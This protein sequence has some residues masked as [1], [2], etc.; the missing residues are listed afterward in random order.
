MDAI[1]FDR[2]IRAQ[3]H[4]PA[5]NAA[6]LGLAILS[7][8]Y[9]F[10]TRMRAFAYDRRWLPVHQ[11]AIPVVSIGNLTLGG[12]G[13]TPMV[14]WVSRW[15][16]RH[17]IRVVI[18]SRGYGATHGPNDE[19][20]V[21]E[22]N[23]PDCPHLQGADRVQLARIAVEELEGQV[24]ILDDA[25]QHRRL[26]RDLDIVL[27]DALEPFGLN[28]LFPRG[29]L[30]EPVSALRRAHVVVL[31][32]A[33]QVTPA[34][35]FAIRK[36][37]ESVC[38]RSL[39]WV[40]VRHAPRAASVHQEHPI[41][42]TELPSFRSVGFCGIGNPQAFRQTLADLGVQPVDF[43]IFPDHHPYSRDDVARLADWIR[44]TH[45]ELAL[46]TQ[47]DS[48]KLLLAHLGPARIAAIEIGL[49]ILQGAEIL[50]SALE[51]VRLR[52]MPLPG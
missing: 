41:P 24:L 32:R 5:H 52:M 36:A 19:A 21:L 2:I 33:D 45:A 48:V 17:G 44:S 46:T 1:T 43:R 4:S 9:G 31:S 28:H 51:Q 30:R 11:A 40:E 35:R 14:E 13:K 3:D 42:L 29:R 39:P 15:F 50:G 47:K 6:R 49:E 25:F 34:E 26:A 18:A 37:A 10:G 23:L 8:G 27:L 12:T 20:L 16:R 22:N 7:W 38:R